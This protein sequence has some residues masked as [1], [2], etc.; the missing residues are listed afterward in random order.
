[1][2][3]V[4]EV[5]AFDEDT[6]ELLTD[7]HTKTFLN[8]APL[9]KFEVGHRWVAC[10]RKTAVAFAGVV[11]AT[12]IPDCGYFCRIGVVR[13]HC[14]HGLQLRLMRA[15][16]SRARRNGWRGIVSDTTDN[17]VSANN[18]IRAGYCL[19]EPPFPWGWAHTLYWRKRLSPML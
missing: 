8:S 10:R 14:G 17:L 4:R 7:L 5:D 3:R 18:F 2:Y 16:E 6:I 11:P 9:P 13:E 12:A 15:V 19:F 1:M